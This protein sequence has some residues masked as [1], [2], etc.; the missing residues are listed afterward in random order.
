M[1]KGSREKSIRVVFFLCLSL[2]GLC[3]A[4]SGLGVA[5]GN[6][7]VSLVGFFSALLLLALLRLLLWGIGSGPRRG[8]RAR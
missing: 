3:I 7:T 4:L 5:F 1:T 2:L 8:R 6:R